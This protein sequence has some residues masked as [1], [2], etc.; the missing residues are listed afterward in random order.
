MCRASRVA[1]FGFG[2]AGTPKPAFGGFPAAATPSAAAP[3]FGAPKPALGTP[4]G[5]NLAAVSPAATPLTVA[6]LGTKPA[7]GMP[8]G[9]PGGFTGFPKPAAAGMQLPGLPTLGASTTLAAASLA[10][11]TPAFSMPGASLAPTAS[12]AAPLGALREMHA[13]IE[14]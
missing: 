5:F 9:T 4:G 12:S 8:T 7:L 13:T 10:A 1:A 11:P 6:A 2:A 3:M 14:R